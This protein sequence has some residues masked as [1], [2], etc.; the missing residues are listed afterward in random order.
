MLQVPDLGAKV[1]AALDRY[2]SEPAICS[3]APPDGFPEP[4][5]VA[6]APAPHPG[7]A[8]QGSPPER[9]AAEPGAGVLTD[10]TW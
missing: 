10:S 5:N 1:E 9:A 2:M 6:G 3:A 4:P 7:S 8:A